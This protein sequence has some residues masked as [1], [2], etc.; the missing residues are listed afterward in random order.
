M[1]LLNWTP[2]KGSPY[3]IPRNRY[4]FDKAPWRILSKE[5]ISKVSFYFGK[6]RTILEDIR[7]NLDCYVWMFLL[8]DDPTVTKMISGVKGKT[9]LEF[10][11]D[12]LTTYI[13]Y[14]MAETIEVKIPLVKWSN[15]L[16][17]EQWVGHLMWQVA[18]VYEELYKN[19]WKEVGVYG[20]DISDLAFGNLI[21][22]DNG[23]MELYMES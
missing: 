23:V 6:E 12:V 7:V 4:V 21:I 17:E 2:D 9:E 10:V 15:S 16:F 13:N 19:H 3:Q 8:I 18:K 20:H 5:E 1:P 22:D 14:P 11:T